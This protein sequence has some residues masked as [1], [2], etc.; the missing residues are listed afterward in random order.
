MRF[1]LWTSDTFPSQPLTNLSAHTASPIAA[2]SCSAPRFSRQKKP[3]PATQCFYQLTSAS[4]LCWS[5]ELGKTL[6]PISGYLF[7]SFPSSA[8]SS[9]LFTFTALPKELIKALRTRGDQISTSLQSY[10][11][12][13]RRGEWG[14]GLEWRNEWTRHC[15]KR[16]KGALA[17]VCVLAGTMCISLGHWLTDRELIS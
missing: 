1:W 4:L 5:G 6:G 15:Q 3:P 10:G 7:P 16:L 13:N 12:Q 8:A 14:E 17:K 11:V 9:T 2:S